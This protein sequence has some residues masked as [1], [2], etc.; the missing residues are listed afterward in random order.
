MKDFLR[1]LISKDFLKQLLYVLIF[2][3]LVALLV[4]FWL[5]SYTHSGQ[6]LILPSYV[7]KYVEDAQKQAKD[8]T[9]QII[10]KDSIH[11]VGETG[12]KIL[13]Q[14]PLASAEV[15]EGRKV[16]VT[17]TKFRPDTYMLDELPKLYGNEFNQRQK[18]LERF[19][20]KSVIKAR[21]YDPGE[22]NH[23]LEVYYN[24]RKIVSQ[25]KVDNNVKI[26]KGG[27]LEFI[28]SDRAGG[29]ILIPNLICQEFSAAEFLL[30]AGNKLKIGRILNVGDIT[31]KN[32]AYVI[33]QSPRADGVSEI[34][35]GSS[36]NI[37][38]S[39]EKPEF[40]N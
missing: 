37:S 13:D 17:V 25:N 20:I 12:G 4:L 28:V 33:D 31:D 38:I 16:Y 11:V 18:D 36:I 7:G 9:F 26:E 5:K 24:G 30:K 6:K 29:V 23:I 22:P 27:T 1:F 15:K 8:E 19:E 10:V 35:M 40:C 39:Q 14:T 2:L 34:D 32:T 3:A 21:Q